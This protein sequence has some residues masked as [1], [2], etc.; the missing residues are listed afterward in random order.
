MENICYFSS[1][2][3]DSIVS[4]YI[5]YYLRQLRESG[6]DIVFISTSPSMSQL[7][8]KRLQEIV[9]FVVHR[10][11]LG[12][13]FYSW[14]I[15][16]MVR[17]PAEKTQRVLLAND[18]VFGPVFPIDSFLSRMQDCDLDMVGITDSWW[19]SYH[20]Q[21]YFLYFSQKVVE[22]GFL[23]RF[24]NDVRVLS[25][26]TDII[27]QYEIGISKK[28]ARERFTIGALVEY[29]RLYQ[30][31]YTNTSTISQDYVRDAT[32]FFWKELLTQKKSPFIK[33]SIWK[34]LPADECLYSPLVEDVLRKNGSGFSV[35]LIDCHLKRVI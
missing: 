27:N 11:N 34:V 8:L 32:V 14:K 21:S 20:V 22:S 7:D 28:L 17:P 4:D 2:D 29:I 1:F 6:F 30:D 3:R 31:N 18:S 35:E 26:K 15:G 5:F 9:A 25:S 24:F 13:D 10:A 23:Q 16:M 33:K 19:I 12:Y